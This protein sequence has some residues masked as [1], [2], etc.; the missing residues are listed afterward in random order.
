MNNPQ[1]KGTRPLTHPWN[2][3]RRAIINK[4]RLRARVNNNNLIGEVNMPVD[5]I[6]ARMAELG[7]KKATQGLTPAEEKE[8]AE[9]K[10]QLAME[11]LR[12]NG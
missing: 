3:R 4:S 1:F 6:K 2:K 8:L 7:F 12:D 5:N 9:L 11:R 10:R